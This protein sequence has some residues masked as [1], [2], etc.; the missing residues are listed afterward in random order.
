[1]PTD[2]RSR[3]AVAALVLALLAGCGERSEPLGELEQPYPVTVQGAGERPTELAAKPE[4][5]VALDPASVELVLA[6][7][8]RDRLVGVPEGMRRGEGPL[9]APPAAA[10]VVT[11]TQRVRVD[12]VAAAEPDLI[13]ATT[14][15]DLV[16]VARAQ[17]RSEAA[18]YVQP[19]TSVDDV[20]RAILELGFLLG[21][22]VAARQLASDVRSQ[23]AAVEA[24]VAD[25]PVVTTFVDTG[26]F[27]TIPERSLLGDLIVRARG[28]SVAGPAPGPTPFP[29]GR[30]RRVDPEVYLAT[31]DS[32]V[33]LADLRRNPQTAGLHAVEERRFAILPSTLV[34]R[35]GPRVGRA[36]EQVAEALHPNAFG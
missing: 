35:A 13:V 25:E 21:E 6:L 36:L 11:G 34:H 1:M 19:S 3:V 15:S 12:A 14:A 20:L 30:L 33:T 29:L 31:T 8:A 5:V 22:P 17:R 32:R 7:G 26:F 18:L 9:E 24:R 10:E 2:V 28:E 16:E 27:I 23:V 4:R